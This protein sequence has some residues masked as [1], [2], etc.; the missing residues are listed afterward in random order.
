[1]KV[2][3]AVRLCLG[4]VKDLILFSVSTEYVTKRGRRT[5]KVRVWND[6]GHLTLPEGCDGVDGEVD[7]HDEKFIWSFK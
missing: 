6:F 7:R 2:T 1:M 5:H 3:D 4:Y